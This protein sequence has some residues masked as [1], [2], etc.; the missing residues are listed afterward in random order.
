MKDIS[1]DFAEHIAQNVTTIARVWKIRRSDGAVFGFTDHDCDINFDGVVYKAD[2]GVDSSESV[3]SSGLS[4]GG[5]EVYGALSSAA[6]NEQELLSGLWDGAIVEIWLVN[7][8]NVSQRLHQSTYTIGEVVRSGTHFC[9]ELR[10]LMQVLDRTSGRIYQHR[11]DAMFGDKACSLNKSHPE[12][13]TPGSIS[14]VESNRKLKVTLDSSMHTS[15]EQPGVFAHGLLRFISGENK[16]RSME[17]RLDSGTG[18][19]RVLDLW[20]PVVLP[21]A[22]GDRFVVTVGCDKRFE[23]CHKRFANSA[24]FRGFP[25]IPGSDHTLS[26]AHQSVSRKPGEAYVP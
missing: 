17:I 10:S 2:T 4:A 1:E 20:Q 25:H 24:N 13:Q 8:Q 19:N 16:S 3:I 14:S 15:M 22:L 11:C 23:T 6:I 26:L 5:Q 18:R 12:F 7:W 9:A 21:V